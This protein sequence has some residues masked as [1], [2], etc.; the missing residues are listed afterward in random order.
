MYAVGVSC[1]VCGIQGH[2][3]ADCQ[4][5][6]QG[7]EQVNVFQ[8]YSPRPQNNPYSNTY[9]PGWRNH[10]NFSYRNSN[11]LPPNV[12]QPQQP[13]LPYK[14]PYNP[15]PPPPQ[16]KSNLESLMERFIATQT[17]TNE[18]FSVSTNQLNA[19]FDAMASHQKAMDN[20]I[21]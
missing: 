1:E 15:P 8:N 11:P 2:V 14:A 4:A 9:N 5:Q 6:L 21:A 3:A 10:P 20:Q 19:K 12:S 16:P 7:V 18:V 17:K 13:N